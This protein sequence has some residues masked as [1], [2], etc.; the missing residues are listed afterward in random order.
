MRVGE[1]CADPGGPSNPV[2]RNR[3]DARYGAVGTG[4]DLARLRGSPYGDS[5]FPKRRAPSTDAILEPPPVAAASVR[6]DSSRRDGRLQVRSGMMGRLARYQLF[7]IAW[8][9]HWQE[10]PSESAN[11][12]SLTAA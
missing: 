1:R 12:P 2:G 9:V 10:Q 11:A 5:S 4:Q 6:G 7:P 3:S 8:C